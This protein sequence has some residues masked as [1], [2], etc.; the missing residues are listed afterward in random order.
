M[1]SL[2]WNLPCGA[3][4]AK[5]IKGG[6]KK[7]NWDKVKLGI[8]QGKQSWEWHEPCC[9]SVWAAQSGGSLKSPPQ[10]GKSHSDH[11]WP[12]WQLLPLMCFTSSLL[13]PKQRAAFTN[14]MHGRALRRIGYAL[15][16]AR[17]NSRTSLG[18][19]T[20]GKH[21]RPWVSLAPCSSSAG[22]TVLAQRCYSHMVHSAEPTGT[23][24]A[25]QNIQYIWQVKFV[26]I[27]L[28]EHQHT[29]GISFNIFPEIKNL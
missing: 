13:S 27:V 17:G 21:R 14:R 8:E 1:P 24:S 29:S 5:L 3:M 26:L 9:G 28:H 7:I 12:R 11:Q 10:P 2:R 18:S 25:L 23:H 22:L 19:A 15:Q 16:P 4:C 6:K 20:A